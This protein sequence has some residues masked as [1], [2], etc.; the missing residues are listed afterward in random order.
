MTM[1]S[2][3]WLWSAFL[4]IAAVEGPAA[5]ADEAPLPGHCAMPPAQIQ[6][7]KAL[8]AKFFRPGITPQER[9]ALFDVDYIQHNPLFVKLSQEK[10]ISAYEEFKRVFSRL[11]PPSRAKPPTPSAAAA[12]PPGPQVVILTAECDIVTVIRRVIRPDPTAAGLNQETFT[13]DTFR[14]RNGKLLEHWDGEV[15]SEQS[16][17]ELRML[18]EPA[19]TPPV[20]GN[21]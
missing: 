14:V 15:I 19:H 12:A 10:H 4:A 6:E 8:A 17:R 18:D 1:R 21:P 3:H 11:G 20:A 9:V 7:E 13:W 5:V 2:K 16:L